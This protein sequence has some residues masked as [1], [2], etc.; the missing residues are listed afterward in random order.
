MPL[1]PLE[2]EL[3]AAVRHALITCQLHGENSLTI[4]KLKE[5]IKHAE[6]KEKE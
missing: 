2:R 3:L 5:A 4:R 1:T 6:E